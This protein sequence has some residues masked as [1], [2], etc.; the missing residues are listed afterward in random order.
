[1]V[2]HILLYVCTYVQYVLYVLYACTVVLEFKREIHL[3]C[4]SSIEWAL[5][6]WM[7][8]LDDSKTIDY[9]YYVTWCLCSNFNMLISTQP[10]PR[11]CGAPVSEIIVCSLVFRMIHVGDEYQAEVDDFCEGV[12]TCMC[13]WVW[14]WGVRLCVCVCVCVWVCGC[15][16]GCV[17][18]KYIRIYVL[19]VHMYTRCACR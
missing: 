4:I 13:V 2:H 11:V 10:L 18:D 14:V 9:L 5:V 19:Y 17:Y 12:C 15:G 6:V 16:C 3:L 7:C 8:F 1:M